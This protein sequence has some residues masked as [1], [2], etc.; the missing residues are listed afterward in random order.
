MSYLSPN[1]FHWRINVKLPKDRTRPGTLV[2]LDP[3][4]M[5]IVYA[6]TCLG[7]ADGNKARAKN[8]IERDTTRPWGDFPLGKYQLSE[9]KFFAQ[10][11]D[12]FGVGWLPIEGANGD[13]EKALKNGRTGLAVHSG[14]GNDRLVP[15]YG[16]LRL[17]DRDFE[18]I[19]AILEGDAVEVFAAEADY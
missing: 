4:D 10:Y 13:A 15:T 2:V 16:C 1:S 3:A 5:R 12:G 6:C 11:A 14:R 17:F 7:K 8:N 19:S 18:A 9:I